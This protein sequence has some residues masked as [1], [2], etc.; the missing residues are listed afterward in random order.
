[1]NITVLVACSVYLACLSP[2]AFAAIA[3]VIAG[4]IW[5]HR[6]LSARA[7][8]AVRA[9]RAQQDRLFTH[10]RALT[11][12]LG[13]LKRHAR[14][15]AAFFDRGLDETSLA[16][17][18][19]NLR[20][21]ARFGV[22]HLWS[23]A[24]VYLALGAV[25]FGAGTIRTLPGSATTGFVVT[26]V[27]LTGPL[28]A[29]LLVVPM[30]GRASVALAR[31]QA[32]GLNADPA[33]EISRAPSPFRSTWQ[34][35]E[36]DRVVHAY[37][38][39]DDAFVLGPVSLELSRGEILFVTG[40][41]GSGKS[42]LAK[43]LAGL[44]EPLSGSVRVDG[45][46]VDATNRTHFQE[47]STS[48]LSQFY[49]FDTLL[50]L[51]DAAIDRDAARL[52]E[53]LGLSRKVH[54]D[55]GRLSTTDLSQG[56]RKRLALLTATLEKRSLYVLDEWAADQDAGFKRVFYSE[57]L[58]ELR[59]AGHTAVVI[60]HDERFFYAADRIVRLEEGALVTEIEEPIHA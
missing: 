4:G 35:I 8:N 51:D 1:V 31:V 49:L 53:R 13:E 55:R 43:I 45:V 48:V 40:G 22:A 56:Q 29:A 36:L 28:A 34:K 47:L 59:A 50:G 3:A 17:E 26:I 20:A 15:R 54:V 30:F 41:N 42:T 18:H 57:L 44:Y 38:E 2:I 33:P 46:P 5:I 11:E 39:G 19:E 9:A 21:T 14:R 37:G 6:A 7:M 60:S 52:L 27:Y 58:P 32:L 24:V 10:F 25:L 23:Q 16:L 12:G